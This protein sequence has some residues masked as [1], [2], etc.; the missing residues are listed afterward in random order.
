LA[1]PL[2]IN[3]A[4]GRLFPPVHAKCRRLLGHSQA[5]EDVAQE[6]FVRLWRSGLLERESGIPVVMAWLYRTATRLSIDLLRDRQGR[7]APPAPDE[8]FG[9]GVDL[10]TRTEARGLIATLAASVPEEELAAA[11]LC[12]VDGLSQLEAA[13]VLE[14]SE[15]TLRRTLSRFDERTGS[16]RK[17]FTS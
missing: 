11:V 17:E 6:A 14:M 12:R 3:E 13:A 1:L 2:D 4:Y 15:R 10:G 5:S 16:L 7:V 8:A 9:C